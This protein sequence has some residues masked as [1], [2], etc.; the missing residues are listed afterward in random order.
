MRPVIAYPGTEGS[1]SHAAARRTFEGGELVSFPTFREVAQA[2]V[3]HRADYGLLPVE[4]SSAGAVLPTYKLLEALPLTIAAEVMEPVRHQLLGVPGATLAGI[5]R[6]TSHPQAIAQCDRFLAGLTGVAIVPSENTALSAREVAEKGDPTVAAIASR[7]AAE[8]FGLRVLAED[9]Q[10]SSHNVT[11]FYVIAC[12][13]EP[14]GV[15][16]KAT[17]IFTVNNEVGALVRVLSIFAEHG[18]NM[19]RIESRP[20]PE[21]AFYYFF[22][23]DLE[24]DMDAAHLHRAMQA[25]RPY[26]QQLRLLGTYPKAARP[27]A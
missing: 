17:V 25:A 8:R 11:R 20:L 23:V 6:I 7:Q 4:N 9:I 12:G 27:E 24:G 21:S 13:R 14:L 10:T 1:F 15:P 16:D 22:S 18:L 19:S 2:V 3:E 26:T 5:R